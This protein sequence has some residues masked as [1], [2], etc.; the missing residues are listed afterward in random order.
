[1]PGLTLV[2]ITPKEHVACILYLLPFVGA[3]CT[4]K[5]ICIH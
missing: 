3:V 4:G 2:G 1:M 5:N